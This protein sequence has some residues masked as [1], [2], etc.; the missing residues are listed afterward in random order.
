MTLSGLGLGPPLEH[1]H[2]CSRAGC[3]DAAVWA[4]RW[5]NPKIHS[6]DRR[7]IWL[8]CDAHRQVLADFLSDRSFPLDIVTVGELDE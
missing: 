4:I 7:K 3:R 6:A 2:T 1:T 5:R 8:A